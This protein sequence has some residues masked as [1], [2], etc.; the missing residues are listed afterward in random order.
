MLGI[1]RTSFVM[2]AILTGLTGV[3]YPLA[4]TGLAKIL[5]PSESEG[6]LVIREGRPIGSS[7]IGQPFS[8]NGYFWSRPSATS[9]TPYN[10]AA[11]GG[12][13]LGPLNPTLE[14]NVKARIEDLRRGD[15]GI[16]RIPADLVTASGS[17]LDPHLS[18]AS[19]EL[20]VPRVARARGRS[21]DEIQRLV[22]RFTEGRQWGLLGEP[23]VNVLLLN[24]ALDEA[25]RPR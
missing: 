20:Q 13:N 17:G 10:A 5:F 15:P 11:S 14:A 24:L 18:P 8:Q 7:L 2:L 3:V 9:P 4:V 6:S 22:A 21:E 19:V 25:T 1:L 12:S 16:R 23:R